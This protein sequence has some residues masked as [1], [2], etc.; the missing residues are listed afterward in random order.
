MYKDKLPS[1]IPIKKC[2]GGG[3]RAIEVQLHDCSHLATTNDFNNQEV[4]QP[5]ILSQL[6][7]I[8]LIEEASGVFFEC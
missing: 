1:H 3:G 2:R 4:K 5:K 7:L 8:D 6:L